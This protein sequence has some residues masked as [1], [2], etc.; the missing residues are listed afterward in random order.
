MVT[1]RP[2][3]PCTRHRPAGWRPSRSSRRL[4]RGSTLL[5]RPPSGRPSRRAAVDRIASPLSLEPGR[6]QTD[7]SMGPGSTALT[8]IRG[9]YSTA[10]WRVRETMPPFA[11]AYAGW[12][13]KP[14]ITMS[15]PAPSSSSSAEI[16]ALDAP[17]PS[18][19]SGDPGSGRQPRPM[20]PG[21]PSQRGAE[22]AH[23]PSTVD[24]HPIAQ[25]SGHAIEPV[26]RAR[27][28][29]DQRCVTQVDAVRHPHAHPGRATR[30][31][32]HW[33][34]WGQGSRVLYAERPSL[35]VLADSGGS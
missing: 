11:A 8:R 20:R 24:Q 28:R 16:T 4:M 21:T 2:S 19:R 34:C 10:S 26:D 27:Q 6:F 15:R 7:V 13:G 32:P 29:L 22:Q 3:A 30:T 5:P 12:F 33:A 14:S 23:R 18:P 17:T 1:S 31:S 9:P 25:L 35:Q